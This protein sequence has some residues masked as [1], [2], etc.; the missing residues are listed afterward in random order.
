MSD[1]K[2]QRKAIFVSEKIFCEFKEAA[3]KDGRK[4]TEFL[5]KLLEIYYQV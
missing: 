4:Y 5:K 3:Q 1:K 2:K